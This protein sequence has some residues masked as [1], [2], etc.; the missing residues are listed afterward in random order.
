MAWSSRRTTPRHRSGSR[1]T[2]NGHQPPEHR[3]AGHEGRVYEFGPEVPRDDV[4]SRHA[5][6]I[7]WSED[8]MFFFLASA[9]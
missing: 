8:E 3:F 5:L 9:G 4:G 2:S 1:S 7:T 6:A